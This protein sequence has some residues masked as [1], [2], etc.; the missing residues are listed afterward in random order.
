MV[1]ASQTRRATVQKC[2]FLKLYRY[3]FRF[4]RVRRQ[5]NLMIR[6]VPLCE[7]KLFVNRSCPILVLTTVL[8]RPRR[9]DVKK[10]FKNYQEPK[11]AFLSRF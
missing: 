9:A 6:T 3:P 1:R 4:C 2:E 10:G 11:K 5:F 8:G 7:S